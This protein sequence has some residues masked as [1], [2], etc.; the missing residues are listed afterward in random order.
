MP[1]VPSRKR[2]VRSITVART[3]QLTPDMVR[4]TFTG[5]DLA[6]LPDLPFTDHYVK[7]F[8]PPAGADYAWPFDPDELRERL[9]ADQ[10]P[11]T[12]TY[13]IRSFDRGTGELAIDFVVH[14]DE[15]LAGP[16]AARARP[17]DSIGFSGPGGA[18]APPAEA[19]SHLLVGDE[20]AIPAIAAALDRLPAQATARVF[21][22]VA[23]PDHEQPL[24][25]TDDTV[26]EWVH[27]GEHGLGSGMALAAAVRAAGLP[28]GRLSAF[29][30]GNAEMVRD[31]RR[32]L[33]VEKGVDRKQVSIS[34]YWRPG[35]TEDRWQATK[36]EFNRQ[37]DEEESAVA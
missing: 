17:G 31:L 18:W 27:R 22:E 9:P 10:R 33:F 12:R 4:V 8:F 5:D 1:E 14:G 32:F 13:T 2:V 6:T 24:P 3:E 15:G 35:Q 20:A 29:V 28:E 37:M 21:L 19:D 30:H 23:S 34:G 26:V 36:R 11:V 7:L 16:W 25:L